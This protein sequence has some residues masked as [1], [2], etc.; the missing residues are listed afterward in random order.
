MA[1]LA[2]RV[3]GAGQART[4]LTVVE[5][6]ERVPLSFAQRRLWLIGQ[7]EGPSTTYNVPVALSLSG[8]LDEEALGAALRDVL[9]RHEVLRTVFPAD[10]NGEPYQR[11]VPLDE[12]A[13]ELEVA[14]VSRA[15]LADAVATAMAYTF[16]LAAEVPIRAWL[17]S[18]ASEDR[19][20]ALTVHHIASDGW[21]M[22]PLA[23]DISAAYAARR[24]G[25]A[26]EWSP[27]PVQYADYALWQ[28]ELLGDERDPESLL[29]NQVAYWRETLAGAPQELRL[30][31][32]R[33]RPVVASYRGHRV[34]LE[35]PAQV[36]ARLVEVA[37]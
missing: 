11:I 18:D 2:A 23:D 14:E 27:L 30:P 19:I 31:F 34:P 37:R 36:H 13:W 33:L 6:P 25:R 22:A 15:G 5:R 10:E 17:F 26:P 7:L 28:R 16:D 12:L 20:L 29:S 21:S 1:K 3:A 9:G 4:A 32:D 24:E 35:I 8:E